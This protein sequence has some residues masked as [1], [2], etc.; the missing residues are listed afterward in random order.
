M[1]RTVLIGTVALAALGAVPASGAI[2]AQTT[3]PVKVRVSPRAGG[4]RTTFALSFRS[5]WQ[6]GQLGSI[7][8]AQTVEI[9]GTQRPGCVWSGQ[10]AV[11]AA[12]AHLCPMIEIRPQTIAYFSFRVK[13]RS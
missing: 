6:T 5:P 8:R 10:M 11:P 4:P 9:Q 12:L 3:A 1:R 7:H 13:R 2:P